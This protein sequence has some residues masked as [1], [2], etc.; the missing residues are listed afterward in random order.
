MKLIILILINLF[1]TTIGALEINS[2]VGKLRQKRSWVVDILKMKRG[3]EGS[4]GQLT[5]YVNIEECIIYG[6][7]LDKP[8]VGLFDINK[9]TKE[10]K[11]TGNVDY[12]HMK[13]FLLVFECSALKHVYER[14]AVEI[15]IEEIYEPYFS[16]GTYVISAEESML[17]GT[18]LLIMPAPN[19]TQDAL[20]FSVKATPNQHNVMFF[21]NEKRELSFR[22][23]LDYEENKQFAV[24]VEAKNQEIYKPYSSTATV[25]INI[26]DKND[27]IPVIT[28][29]TGTGRVKENEIGVEVYRIQVSDKDSPG[30][31]AWRAKFK[32][33]GAKAEN[34]KIETN[35]KTNEGIVSVVKPLDFEE[36]QELNLT[37][38]VENEEPFFSCTVRKMHYDGQLWDVELSR[39]GSSFS[40][41]SFPITVE[42]VNE[43][44]EFTETVKHVTV[45][46]NTPPGYLLWTINVTDQDQIQPNTHR[47]IKGKDIDNWVSV[48]LK[49]GE[50]TTAKVLDRESVFVSNSTYTVILHAVDDG[51]PRQTGTGTLFIHLLDEN[52]NAPLLMNNKVTVC[53]P[54]SMIN[55]TATDPDLPPFSAPFTYKIQ[56]EKGR[57]RIEPLKGETVRLVKDASVYSGSYELILDIA[58]SGGLSSKQKLTVTVHNCTGERKG[59]T[60]RA[61]ATGTAIIFLGLLLMLCVLL[62]VFKCSRGSKDAEKRQVP[63]LEDS[64]AFVRSYN[65]EG[66]GCDIEEKLQK[67]LR[68][69]PNNHLGTNGQVIVTENDWNS[70]QRHQETTHMTFS[71]QTRTRYK[72]SWETAEKQAFYKKSTS[73]ADS[74]SQTWIIL[75]SMIEKKL[76][77]LQ[78]Q[79]KEL[80]H[81]KPHPYNNEGESGDP[82]QLEALT[83][84]DSNFS[85]DDL[86]NAQISKFQHLAAQCRRDHV[87]QSFTSQS[88]SSLTSSINH[89]GGK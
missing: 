61:G 76:L 11:V 70:H 50:V 23:C 30:S 28:G 89:A 52:D 82:A 27:H 84:A 64:K 58:D 2:S 79:G 69:P 78:D 48:D 25:I 19:K 54:E 53:L 41:L 42:N 13:N 14:L 46:E 40:T 20:T 18:N 21:L 49:T 9:E 36:T 51:I 33:Y 1:I 77:S 31:P 26:I 37:V 34:F 24:V 12:D 67:E 16:N 6:P 65:D 3:F 72:E 22:G 38:K 75:N 8:P 32:L 60:K 45:M 10:M 87:Q 88:S 7:G 85:L 83:L 15:I 55:I 73:S 80:C 68:R 71:H 4:L 47:F 63:D 39:N 44:P 57:W 5:F 17:Q 43:P 66:P 56:N 35:P 86:Q 59:Y 81:Y 74:L 62:L 29:K